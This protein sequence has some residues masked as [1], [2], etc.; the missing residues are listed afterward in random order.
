MSPLKV[1]LTPR[2][3]RTCFGCGRAAGQPALLIAS[4]ISSAVKA[5]SGCADVA[6][7]SDREQSGSPVSG[8][9]ALIARS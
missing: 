2:G 6:L 4:L 7:T 5:R 9:S 8:H 3:W 1:A